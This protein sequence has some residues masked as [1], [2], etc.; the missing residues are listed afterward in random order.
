MKETVIGVVGL[1]IFAA[2]AVT[3]HQNQRRFHKPLL[4]THYQAVMLTDGTLL[5][6]RLD[7]L[8]TD[9]PV[10]R[11]AM[12]V[13][14]IV[15]PTSGAISHKIMLRKSED[16]GADHLILP[17]TSILYVEPVQTDSTIGRAIAQI[18]SR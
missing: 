7:H 14:A 1:L 18:H 12:T 11:E 16:H 4:T 8:G 13:R 15:D 5:H 17:A 9:F 3:V 2:L 10:L 6:G